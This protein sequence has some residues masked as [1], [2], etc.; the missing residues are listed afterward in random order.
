MR[1][2]N[3]NNGINLASMALISEM[4]IIYSRVLTSDIHWFDLAQ[5]PFPKF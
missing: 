3:Q 5:A 1:S 4:E 2:Q